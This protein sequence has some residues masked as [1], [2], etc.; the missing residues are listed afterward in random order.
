MNNDPQENRAGVAQTNEVPQTTLPHIDPTIVPHVRTYSSDIQ[1]VVQTGN[2]S[3]VNILV[4]EK[5]KQLAQ[6]NEAPD[7]EEGHEKKPIGLIIGYIL[8]I[9]LFIAGGV[10]IFLFFQSSSQIN[11]ATLPTSNISSGII[12]TQNTKQLT[13]DQNDALPQIKS[14]ISSVVGSITENNGLFID[15]IPLAIAF[16]E[17]GKRADVNLTL[18]SLLTRIGTADGGFGR[19]GE[20]YMYGVHAGKNPFLLVQVSDADVA[21]GRLFEWEK[22]MAIDMAPLFASLEYESIVTEVQEEIPALEESAPITVDES[23]DENTT[24]TATI[25]SG[26]TGD[27]NE[28]TTETIEEVPIAPK[29]EVIFNPRDVV[30]ADAIFYNFDARI[31]KD[32]KGEIRFIYAFLDNS[33]VVFATSPETLRDI[34]NELKKRTIAR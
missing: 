16:D 3:Q 14:K 33:L 2:I 19:L 12:A 23:Q 24:K 6:K 1:H 22:R 8:S 7:I 32:T 28:T 15:I 21:Y 13:L 30:F 20:K 5:K 29:E 34:A 17:E 4:S 31:I 9:A 18:E 27:T 10:G 26:A 11:T 25:E